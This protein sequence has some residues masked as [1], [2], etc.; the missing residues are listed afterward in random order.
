MLPFKSL[1]L[2]ICTVSLL[3]TDAARSDL[4]MKVKVKSMDVTNKKFDPI[5]YL[6]NYG[7][8]NSEIKHSSLKTNYT[9]ETKENSVTMLKNAIKFFQKFANLNQTGNLDNATLE[10]MKLPRCGLKDF[11]TFKTKKI[12]NREKRFV[13]QG[14]KWSKSDL[15]WTVVKYP[16][17]STMNIRMFDEELTRAFALWSS[18][19][20]LEFEQIFYGTG[21][22][23]IEIS[24]E[25]GYHGDSGQ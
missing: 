5:N 22:A 25:S 8:L 14:S 6:I 24:F 12:L 10:V 1:Y 18:V 19:S 16:A 15:K 20:G 2:I 9:D 21:K 11:N 13:L 17:F 7:Y 23:D 4:Q 3:K